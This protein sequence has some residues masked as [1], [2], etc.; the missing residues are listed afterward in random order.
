MSKIKNQNSEDRRQKSEEKNAKSK[1]ENHNTPLL[2]Y[3]MRFTYHRSHFQDPY[4]IFFLGRGVDM[5]FAAI[6]PCA[7]LLGG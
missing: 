4:S 3:S 2:Q 7:L 1:I 6:I 5:P